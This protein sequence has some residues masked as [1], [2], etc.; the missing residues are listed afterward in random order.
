MQPKYCLLLADCPRAVC[1]TTSTSLVLII[2]CIFHAASSSKPPSLHVR[3]KLVP[4][5]ERFLI[6]SAAGSTATP[7]V[8]QQTPAPVDKRRCCRFTTCEGRVNGSARFRLPRRFSQE[9]FGW[10]QRGRG[11]S[12]E[13]VTK[14][15]KG[16]V[17]TLPLSLDPCGPSIRMAVVSG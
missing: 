12:A 6:A 17:R 13:R 5:S 4:A 2:N 15:T 9:K 8:Q 1:L 10:P 16:A 11:R 3:V 14:A 7:Q